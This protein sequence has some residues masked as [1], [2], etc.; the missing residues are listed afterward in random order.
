MVKHLELLALETLP[1]I[2]QGDDLAG[3]IL[4]ACDRENVELIDSDV[5]VVAQKIVSKSEGRTVRLAEVDCSLEAQRLAEIAGKDPRLVELIL[6]E[7]DEIV[8]CAPGVIIVR[9]RL[10]V[11]LANAGIDQSNV[12][13]FCDGEVALLW[14]LNP[15]ESAVRL[16]RDIADRRGVAVGVI[17][18][19]S[20]GRAWRKGT[21]GVAIGLSGLSAVVDLRGRPDLFGRKLRSTE[22]GQGDEI[23]AAA[24][25]VMGQGDEGRAAVVVRG[26]SYE[27]RE[28]SAQDIVRERNRDLFP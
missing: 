21:V 8:R 13:S 16:R 17:I 22:I 12:A 23:A 10:G 19:D 6:R 1:R 28:S 9:H 24:S 26:M 5:L 27:C 25:L 20:L 14:P 4:A 18:N 3:A 11:V 2:S 7:S 15:D